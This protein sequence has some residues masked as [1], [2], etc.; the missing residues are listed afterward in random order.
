MDRTRADHTPVSSFLKNRLFSLLVG[1]AATLALI[2]V[3]NLHSKFSAPSVD[4]EVSIPS[5]APGADECIY[6]QEKTFYDDPNVTYSIEEPIR[7]WD[8]KRQDWLKHN[9]LIAAGARDKILLVTGSQSG[10]CKNPTGDHLLLRLFK[11]KVDY[12]RIHGYDVFYNNALLHPKMGSFWAKIPVVR[13]AMVAHPEAE[14]IWWVDSDAV[15]TDMDFKPPLERYKDYNL[16]VGGSPELIY[17]KPSWMGLNAGVFY[18]RNC[19]WSMD[20]IEAWAKMGPQTPNYEKWGQILKSTIKD[21]SYPGSDDQTAMVYLLMTEKE[22]W[23]D[24]V[25]L[26]HEYCI[27]GYWAG[28]VGTLDKVTRNYAGIEKRVRMLRRRHAEKVSEGYG[29]LWE[30]YLEEAGY[31]KDAGKR[32]CITHFTGC[33]P[34][35]GNYNPMY[36][37]DSCWKGM[38]KALN[39]AD[40]Q[41]LRNYGFVHRDLLDSSFVSPLQFNFPA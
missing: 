1:A 26:E 31:R 4:M 35:S 34:C 14:W 32:P 21:K 38:E 15:F 3:W 16:V 23:G 7:N 24:K 30:K 28:L 5:P 36:T 8:S 27:Q 37:G 19:Q 6:L 17:E 12:C 40:N 29:A 18:I 20:F 13:A 10:P 9:P 2:I 41:V 25:F 22:K 33:Q 39:F 11:N